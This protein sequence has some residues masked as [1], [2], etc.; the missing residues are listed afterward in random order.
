MAVVLLI[1]T[2]TLL[3]KGDAEVARNTNKEWHV[4]AGFMLLR[5]TMEV[6]QES[7]HRTRLG[8]C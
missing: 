2:A 1:D 5:V 4:S 3:L 8:I 7:K 6:T